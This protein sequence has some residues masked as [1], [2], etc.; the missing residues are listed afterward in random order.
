ADPTH[1][2]AYDAALHAVFLGFTMS[3]IFAHAP[4]ILPAIARRPLP[5]HRRF[6]IPLLL[7]HGSV[8]VRLW[9][10]DAYGSE[11]LRQTGGTVNV[12]AVVLFALLV[13]TRLARRPCLMFRHRHHAHERTAHRNAIP[14]R[15]AV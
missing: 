11:V 5:Y 12:V 14:A 1:G 6:W 15:D 8:A 13:V 10:G 7:L 4:V 9:L 3:M 2:A